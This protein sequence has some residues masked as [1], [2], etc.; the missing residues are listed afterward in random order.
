MREQIVQ[1]QNIEI[2][3]IVMT[4]QESECQSP[5]QLTRELLA[6]AR[7]VSALAKQLKEPT[8]EVVISIS[9]VVASA[10]PFTG[11]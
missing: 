5:A 10:R 7:E 3:R 2:V 4:V 6:A 9:V 11:C 8:T 1:E